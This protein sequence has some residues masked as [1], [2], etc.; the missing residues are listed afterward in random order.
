[1]HHTRTAHKHKCER[2]AKST[3][4]ATKIRKHEKNPN[5]LRNPYRDS[6]CSSHSYKCN[7]CGKILSNMAN[8]ELHANKSGHSDFSESTEEVKPM[9]DEEKA[10]KVLE[11]K[12]LLKAKRAEREEAEKVRMDERLG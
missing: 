7:E 8:L 11:I 6:L 3:S 9:T 4:E 5:H 10:A 12:A 1:M 2:R